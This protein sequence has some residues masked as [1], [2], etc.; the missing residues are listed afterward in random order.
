[1]LLGGVARQPKHADQNR[2][3]LNLSHAQAN[4]IKE[5]LTQASRF[6]SEIPSRRG[7]VESN[8]TLEADFGQDF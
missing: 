3:H 4:K 6:L 5:K 1:M 7:A 8:R 2:L